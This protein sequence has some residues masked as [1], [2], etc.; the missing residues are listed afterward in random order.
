MLDIN[1]KEDEWPLALALIRVILNTGESLIGLVVRF[2]QDSHPNEFLFQKGVPGNPSADAPL[3][4]HIIPTATSDG[5]E[6][7]WFR[8][9][10]KPKEVRYVVCSGWGKHINERV[11]GENAHSI[12]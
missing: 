8:F 10:E 9:G 7:R 4:F 1:N 6:P 3:L 12:A 2:E 5:T 11:L